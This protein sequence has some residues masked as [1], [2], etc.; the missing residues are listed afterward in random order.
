MQRTTRMKRIK[1]ALILS[2]ITLLSI[3][4]LSSAGDLK[5]YTETYEKKLE[6]I[7][8]AHSTKTDE[9]N[10]RY[11]KYLR[12]LGTSVQKQGELDKVKAVTKEIERFIKAKTVSKDVS[13]DTFPDLKK[14]QQ[15]YITHAK[16]L[17]LGKAKQ[18]ISLAEK[19]DRSLGRL[20]KE[21]T[22]AGK[23]D[24]A[25]AVQDERGWV[26]VSE[27]VIVANKIISKSA[28]SSGDTKAKA[29]GKSA[30]K[31]PSQ[32]PALGRSA[33]RAAGEKKRSEVTV[34]KV[35]KDEADDY[36]YPNITGGGFDILEGTLERKNKD[37]IAI[38]F[39]TAKDIPQRLT[40]YSMLITQLDLDVGDQRNDPGAFKTDLNV[41]IYFDPRRGRWSGAVD[42]MS[43]L[44]APEKFT[45]LVLKVKG[46]TA[47]IEIKSKLFKSVRSLRFFLLTHTEATHVD[48]VP[49]NGYEQLN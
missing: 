48:R 4:R 26:K 42:R 37:R 25:T 14:L 38:T 24:D 12:T 10:A 33:G 22:R 29:P 9:M 15:S 32:T 5:T 7:T 40:T 13:K 27:T 23:L 8:L 16:S 28:R 36:M 18:V 31:Q 6:E 2:I 35:L 20:E 41:R 21:L 1:P 11:L 3:A 43:P 34:R 47:T 45:I 39:R 19:Y 30:T 46:N 17:E 49:D 44:T